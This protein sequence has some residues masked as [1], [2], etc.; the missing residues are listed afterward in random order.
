MM[1]VGHG[2]TKTVVQVTVRIIYYVLAM[3]MVNYRRIG[4]SGAP[5]LS[6]A[7]SLLHKVCVDP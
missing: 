3:R 1:N 2:P 6:G 7:C 5:R 4:L